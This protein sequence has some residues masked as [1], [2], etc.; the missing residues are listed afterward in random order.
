MRRLRL[1]LI[2]MVGSGI[3]FSGCGKENA[4]RAVG[5]PASSVGPGSYFERMRAAPIT[6][7]ELD[8]VEKGNKPYRLAL[9][10]KTRN[11]PFFE[12]MI[13]AFEQ[14][15]RLLGCE[16]EVQAPA[17]ESDKEQQFAMVQAVGARGADAILLAPADSR[18]IL[19]ALKQV[20]DKGVLVVNLDNRV[21]RGAAISIDA[22]ID[23]YVGA[24][25]QRGGELAGKKMVELLG[26]KGR[27]A[28]LEGIRGADNAEAR[29]RGFENAVKDKLEVVAKDSAEWDT[30]KAYSKFQS[31][32]A[33][34]KDLAGLFCAND[35]MALGAVKAIKE[36]GQ[37]GK[38]KVIGYDNI[39]DVQP[40]LKSGQLAATIE[41]H[42][43]LMGKYG[44][45]MAVG[46][47]NG[48]LK[49]GR[50][51]LVNLEVITAKP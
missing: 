35:K 45:R 5:P 42:P 38:I 44:V 20:H 27:V 1:L 10:V 13:R 26:G 50:E 6:A 7:A 16:A 49:S 30:Q 12:P 9:I 19:P 23:G 18:A 46:L 22:D 31:M 48:T 15:T 32:L 17:Q 33:A 29:R 47:L 8:K 41:Q 25:N 24:D 2:L 39:P 36:A 4:N 11:N 51:H 14:E 43:D 37:T 3:S 21:D 40:L 28:I 34:N